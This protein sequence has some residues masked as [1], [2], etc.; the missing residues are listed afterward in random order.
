MKI[1]DTINLPQ[2][3]KKLDNEQ[4]NTLCSEIRDFL[5]EKVMKSGGHLASNL[6][7]TELTVALLKTFNF[8]KDKVIYD[9]GHQSYVHKLLTGRKDQFDTL[10]CIKG[11]AGFPKTEESR[12]DSFNTGHASTSISAALGMARARD[13]KGDKYDVIAVIGDGS[14]TGGM[15]FEGLNDAGSSKTKLIIILNDNEMSIEKNVGGLSTY[16]NKIRTAPR[17]SKTKHSVHGIL[18][19]MGAFGE[20][21]ENGLK[22]IKDGI[23][24]AY[25]SGALFEFLGFTYL[26]ICDG[27]DIS[28]LCE[29]LNQAKNINGPVLIHVY[30]KKGLGFADAEDNP[31]KFHGVSRAT[32]S[33]KKSDI[34]YSSVFGALLCCNAEKN[35]NV[36][37]ITAAMPSGCGI[38]EFAARFPE[39]FFDVGIAEQHAVTMSAGLAISG[40]TPVVCIYSTFLQRAYDQI[41]HDVCLQNLHVVFAIDRAGI[42]GEDGETHQGIFDLSFLTHI[43][44]LTVLAPSCYEELKDMLDWAINKYNGPVSIRYPR[45]NAYF[46][47]CTSFE[48]SKSEFLSEGNDITIVAVGNMI[49]TAMEVNDKLR[50]NGIEADVINLR[51]VKPFDKEAIFSSL[52][53]TGFLVTIEDNVVAGGAG[54]FICSNYSKRL[55]TLHFGYNEF[56]PQGKPEELYELYNMS[57]TKI[58]DA[59]IKEWNNFAKQ[60]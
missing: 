60:A 21:L 25:T 59:V 48:I 33:I 42:V 50:A 40:I 18:S 32:M 35:K 51:T 27:N 36:A 53:K 55:K 46:R 26:G 17:Y 15:A 43:P 5:V 7:V 6:G 31:E 29:I 2:D 1:L 24:Y 16:L 11:L 41:L 22:N 49:N 39:R 30:T 23:K 10:R 37:A 13:L 45:G 44:N 9:V 47:E 19:K 3:L 56:I 57:S 58:S 38:T 20:T 8:P 14:M 12:Y 4:L 52:D 34:N 28:Q 54:R